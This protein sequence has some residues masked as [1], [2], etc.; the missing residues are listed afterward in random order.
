LADAYDGSEYVR[1]VEPA[2][3]GGLE[4]QVLNGTNRLELYLQANENQRQAVLVARF[5]NLGKGASG[6]AVQ[7][8][9]LMLG[10]NGHQ[11]NNPLS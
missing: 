3:G 6:A 11:P 4:A 1:V 8:L 2:L 10:L 7:N 9:E 5:D